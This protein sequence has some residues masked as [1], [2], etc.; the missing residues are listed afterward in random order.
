HH[1]AQVS[2]R[3]LDEL[4]IDDARPVSS[5]HPTGDQLR[6]CFP[7]RTRAPLALVWR[8]VDG[9]PVAKAKAKAK[10]A[11][12]ALPAA[13]AGPVA[14]AAAPVGAYGCTRSGKRYKPD[15]P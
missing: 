5:A 9:P 1:Q 15:A 13:G 7:R 6:L 11:A 12:K 14:K 3:V 2:P 8:P 4:Q 10:V